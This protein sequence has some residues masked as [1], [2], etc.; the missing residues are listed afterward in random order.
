MVSR[1]YYFHVVE[2]TCAACAVERFDRS[3]LIVEALVENSGD[4]ESRY[5]F[6]FLSSCA[7][8]IGCRFGCR[9][10][11]F[12]PCILYFDVSRAVP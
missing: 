4:D 2:R 6:C 11:E 9:T 8:F 1:L 10:L 7:V 3:F 5:V 12:S